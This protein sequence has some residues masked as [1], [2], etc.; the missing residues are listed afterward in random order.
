MSKIIF[1]YSDYLDYSNIRWTLYL[2]AADRR[3]HPRVHRRPEGPQGGDCQPAAEEALCARRQGHEAEAV[4]RRSH[5]G[6]G[7]H[8]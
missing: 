3:R 8:L 1:E 6:Q 4:P 7:T 2:Q 5:L